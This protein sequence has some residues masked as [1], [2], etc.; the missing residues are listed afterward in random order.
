[1][2]RI[3]VAQAPICLL[4]LRTER[5]IPAL[6]LGDVEMFECSSRKLGW[7]A[8]V[9]FAVFLFNGT[10]CASTPDAERVLEKLAALEARISAL[11]TEN[12]SIK[13]EAAEA[14]TQARST[15]DRLSYAA[16]PSKRTSAIAYSGIPADPTLLSWTGAYWGASAGGATTRSN[17]ASVER[18]MQSLP[19]NPPPFSLS[20]YDLLGRSG[21]SEVREGSW[22][23]LLAGTHSFR[24]SS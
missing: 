11:E 7:L 3:K 9:L 21:S 2:N 6:Q 13:R 24:I 8:A 5:S 10:A 19:A 4:S 1:M 17:V 16:L 14:H 23:C 18:D 12:R 15:T 22:I 20:G